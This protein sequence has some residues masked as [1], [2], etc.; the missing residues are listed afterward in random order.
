MPFFFH[1][2]NSCSRAAAQSLSLCGCCE[3]GRPCLARH[4]PSRHLIIRGGQSSVFRFNYIYM[5]PSL[6]REQKPFKLVPFRLLLI[7][8]DR[9]WCI[10][11]APGQK[12]DNKLL[13]CKTESYLQRE[14]HSQ[15]QAGGLSASFSCWELARG[16]GLA[17]IY[18]YT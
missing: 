12:T 11:E 5:Q 6:G 3:T 1:H 18:I 2:K 4:T 14:R 13:S 16:Q 15:C 17:F 7:L 8:L 9:S 10:E